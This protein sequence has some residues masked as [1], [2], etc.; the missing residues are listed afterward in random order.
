MTVSTSPRFA[1]RTLVLLAVLSLA[2]VLGPDAASGQESFRV[3]YKV[4]RAS[5]EAVELSGSVSN[6]AAVDVLDVYV[7]AEALDASGK[8]LAR[9]VTWV[10]AGIR[11]GGR[12]AF[13]AKVPAARGTTRYRVTI[14]S[15]RFGFG[16]QQT[17]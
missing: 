4:E 7:T 8:V 5:G 16:G 9:G 15:F 17:P 2:P 1:A 3:T 11:A 6:D 12:E 14:S 13:T 10:S